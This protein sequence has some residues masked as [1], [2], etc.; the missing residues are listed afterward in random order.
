MPRLFVGIDDTLVLYSVVGPNPF[1]ALDGVSY[2]FNEP[3]VQ[4]VKNFRRDNPDALIVLWSG[5]GAQYARRFGD[6]AGLLD[7]VD[8]CMIKDDSTLNFITEGSIV[9]DDMDVAWRTHDPYSWPERNN[10]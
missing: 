4:G 9:V 10:G 1:G 8:L 7:F 6:L 2:I 5:G 3:L